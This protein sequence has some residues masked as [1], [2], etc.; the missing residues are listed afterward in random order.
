MLRFILF[1]VV[2]MIVAL[3]APAKARAADYVVDTERSEF[4][5][6]LFKGGIAAALAHDHVIRATEFEGGASFDPEAPGEASIWVEVEVAS[7][8]ADEPEIRERYGLEG[9]IRDKDRRKIQAT[10]LSVE[11][12]D[13]DNFS[14]IF[15]NPQ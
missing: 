6:Q 5:A 3:V 4:V 14:E 2:A 7:L 13:V 8:K 1:T 11:Q 15:D 9:T 10:M 12:L